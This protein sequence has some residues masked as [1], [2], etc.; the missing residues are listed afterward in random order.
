MKKHR[1]KR[2]KINKSIKKGLPPGSI[3]YIG[4]ETSQPATMRLI[5]Y[6]PEKVV[7]QP[8]TI[9]ELN[10]K[11][12]LKVNWLNVDGISDTEL[13]SNLGKQFSL[14]PLIL[15]DIVNT[16]KR[17][18]EDEYEDCIVVRLK[19]INFAEET[20]SLDTESITLI[21]KSNWIFTFQEKPGDLFNPIRERLKIPQSR[22][23][24][25]S[26]DYLFYALIDIIVDQYFLILDRMEE[27]LDKIE[28]KT[29]DLNTSYL[30]PINELKSKLIYLNKNLRNLNEVIL[31][32]SK[33]DRFIDDKTKDY[34][35]DTLDH[36]YQ[37]NDQLD[38]FF[39]RLNHQIDS[40]HTEANLRLSESMNLLTIIGTIFIPLTFITS[41]YGMNF[42][43]IP[44]LHW[45]YSYPVLW[46][47]LITVG[48]VLYVFLTRRNR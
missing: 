11:E 31:S 47:V 23:R 48:L 43:W 8:I 21:L 17:V 6:G 24:S 45:K 19:M 26:S 20:D 4:P 18:S 37:I 22:A 10:T 36:A 41:I 33:I 39:D 30:D 42:E 27:E 28:D 12:E 46:A 2:K 25:K 16:E 1:K 40:F 29:I 9:N 38:N 7:D 3:V 5:Q 35:K 14:H 15:E 34:L 44:E 13:I 32:L